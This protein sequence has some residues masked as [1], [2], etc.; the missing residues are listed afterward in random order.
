MVPL[1]PSQRDIH[2]SEDP[3]DQGYSVLVELRFESGDR[4]SRSPNTYQHNS[5]HLQINSL[6]DLYSMD[7]AWHSEC[8]REHGRVS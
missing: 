1:L 3:F 4:E 5:F 6:V 8:G 2:K 7:Q